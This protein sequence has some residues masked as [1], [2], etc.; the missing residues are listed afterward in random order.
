MTPQE[1]TLW[2]K[3]E[4]ARL[5]ELRRGLSVEARQ[6]HDRLLLD[7]LKAV[8]GDVSGRVVSVYWPIK[9]EP[10]LKP[11]MN[12]IMEQGG[13]CALP[14]V[15]RHGLPLIFKSWSK[16]EPLERGVWNIP[17]PAGG[18]TVIPDIALAPVVGF[19]RHRYRLGYGGGFFDR[20]LAALP[21]K[22]FV[23]GIGDAQAEIETIHPQD[24]DIPMSIIVTECE[25]I[26]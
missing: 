5:L 25:V 19:D 8:A 18:Q 4:R 7:R 3:A 22:P 21:R 6:S 12:W 13:T 15:E 11:F 23:I 14:V 26:E 9:K 2:R 10:D 16:G 1:L 17:V 20:T 24:H